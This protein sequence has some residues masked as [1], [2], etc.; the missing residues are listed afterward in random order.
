MVNLTPIDVPPTIEEDDDREIPPVAV[1]D[2]SNDDDDFGE[3]D[4]GDDDAEE[5][6]DDDDEDASSYTSASALEEEARYAATN[7]PACGL[8][9]RLV[10][11]RGV[12]TLQALDEQE[13]EARA[14]SSVGI[15]PFTG[16]PLLARVDTVLGFER[17]VRRAGPAS[18]PISPGVPSA[19]F[20]ASS[21]A[22]PLA[23][24]PP[25][26]T[27][28]SGLPEVADAFAAV[29]DKDD[30]DELLLGHDGLGLKPPPPPLST[31]SQTSA[32]TASTSDL[33]VA[34]PSVATPVAGEPTAA[35]QEELC[36]SKEPKAE[37]VSVRRVDTMELL[38]DWEEGH[39]AKRQR[40][41][42]A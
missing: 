15:S 40:A 3:E 22:T 32:S 29:D 11:R 1:E 27:S 34:S 35:A 18:G 2:A 10:V 16:A 38:Q 37:L 23:V 39:A 19:T 36:L 31:R 42:E 12:Q 25:V 5:E 13:E 33:F 6:E 26:M 4:E 41:T 14:A 30:A 7:E 24:P 8:S 17:A 28:L 20:A 21:S 9:P